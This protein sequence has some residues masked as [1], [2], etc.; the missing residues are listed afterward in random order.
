MATRPAVI[1]FQAVRRLDRKRSDVF[2]QHYECVHI[3]L[4][5]RICNRDFSMWRR[6]LPIAWLSLRALA[7]LA[8]PFSP[9]ILDLMTWFKA[10]GV[11]ATGL[12]SLLSPISFPSLRLN[13]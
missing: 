12:L 9:A 1:D 10:F 5:L 7:F 2:W 4:S 3:F 6:C 8:T 13:G 11:R